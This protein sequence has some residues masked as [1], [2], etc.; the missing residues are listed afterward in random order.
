[1][2]EIGTVAEASAQ[3]TGVK[4]SLEVEQTAVGGI[5]DRLETA[6]GRMEIM[7]EYFEGLAGV[8]NAN[9]LPSYDEAVATQ[10][11]EEIG[12]EIDSAADSAE[13]LINE[14]KEIDSRLETLGTQIANLMAR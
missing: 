13:S 11:C 4:N 10:M 2:S 5:K 3:N 8:L 14:L 6:A 1:M 9:A 7:K 12:A